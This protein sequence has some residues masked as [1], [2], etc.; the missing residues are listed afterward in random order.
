[1]MAQDATTTGDST[2]K[3]TVAETT[4]TSSSTNVTSDILALQNG[5]VTLSLTT[6]ALTIDGTPG[7]IPRIIH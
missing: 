5:T 4:S 2:K 7:R 3:S 6:N 1:M